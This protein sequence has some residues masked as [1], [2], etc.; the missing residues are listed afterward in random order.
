MKRELLERKVTAALKDA[1]KVLRLADGDIIV[2]RDEGAYGAIGALVSKG[3]AIDKRAAFI[4]A[5]AGLEKVSRE[6]LEQ[7]LAQTRRIITL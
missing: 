2:V 7:A 4:F 5:P 1:L 3:F 6:D